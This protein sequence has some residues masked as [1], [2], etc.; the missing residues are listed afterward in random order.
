MEPIKKIEIKNFKSIRHQII[1]GCKRINVFIGYPNTGKSNILEALSL[2]S[3]KNPDIPFSSLIRMDGNATLFFNG[4]IDKPFELVIN[5]KH[6][7]KGNYYK[8]NLRIIYEVALNNYEFDEID[9]FVE[10]GKE[11][12][13]SF[14]LRD[15]KI[16]S[17]VSSGIL[18]KDS[19][20]N[21]KKYEFEGNVNY[22]EGSYDTLM[23]PF[24]NNIF[25]VLSSKESI[26]KDIYDLFKNYELKFSFDK[27]TR[28]FKILKNIG[29]DI[30]LISYSMISD[31]LRRLIFY[32]TA[33]ASNGETV[34]LF[35]EPEAH[36][37]PPFIK[38]FTTDIIFDQTNQ[39]FMA[40]HSP[41]VLDEL[42]AEAQ[43]ELSVYLVDYKDGETKAYFL[44][45]EDL[46]EIRA[47]GVDLFF[48]IE[49]YL[50]HG[51]INND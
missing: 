37:F 26:R 4:N 11:E 10:G 23:T 44:N 47:Y 49:S 48:N 21:V 29:D 25:D 28:T 5:K 13:L 41:Y 32:K 46:V 2:F 51:Q 34:L 8:E 14:E 35:E 19:L 24:G 31:T 39:F 30:F 20:Q 43:D 16:N 15:K 7:Y 50:K 1:D 3:I 17:F 38:K 27:S 45:E 42:I 22:K 9:T 33:I 12:C 40:T 18:K 6:R 36:M